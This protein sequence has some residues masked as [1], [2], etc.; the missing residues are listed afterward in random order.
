MDIFTLVSIHRN[1]LFADCNPREGVHIQSRA[2]RIT[3]PVLNFFT[4]QKILLK[5]NTGGKIK[6][7]NH[8]ILKD[9]KLRIHFN[10]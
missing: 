1:S 5:D 2:L 3:C 8:S 10:T 7:N 6:T 9:T 4:S